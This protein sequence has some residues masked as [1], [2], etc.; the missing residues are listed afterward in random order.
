MTIEKIINCAIDDT[1]KFIAIITLLITILSQTLV[2]IEYFRLKG[3]WDYYFIDDTGR[4]AIN[5]GFNPEYLATSL[6]IFA[7]LLFMLLSNQVKSIICNT[8][9]SIVAIV[10]ITSIIFI[11]SYIIF[12]FFS[13]ENKDKGIYS[14]KEFFR[15]VLEKSL[16]T[17]I[18]YSILLS[19]FCLAYNL[20]IKHKLLSSMALIVLGGVF[21]LSYEYYAAKIRTSRNKKFDI[22]VDDGREYCVLEKINRDKFYAV[23]MKTDGENLHLFLDQWVLICSERVQVSAKKYKKIIRHYIDLCK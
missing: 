23:N 11:L 21:G 12:Y 16:F 5:K 14:N 4:H 1:A 20:V 18:K 22:I 15:F 13:K 2:I 8:I 10:L 7:I 17:T 9:Y 3:R 6:F 19:V